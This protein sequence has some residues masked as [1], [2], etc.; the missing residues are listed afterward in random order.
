MLYTQPAVHT[1]R[2]QLTNTFN[3]PLLTLTLALSQPLTL[4]IGPFPAPFGRPC[5]YIQIQELVA[6]RGCIDTFILILAIFLQKS[7]C[8]K[9]FVSIIT[10]P[11]QNGYNVCSYI[12]LHFISFNF[13]FTN[14]K[15]GNG[16]HASCRA[17]PPPRYHLPWV[18]TNHAPA[19]PASF[20]TTHVTHRH[21]GRTGLNI[22]HAPAVKPPKDR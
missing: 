13:L 3:S 16:R 4:T 8:F 12:L 9:N 14:K 10:S 2:W 1:E 18:C 21:T 20:R 17:A 5:V 6:V 11:P 7:L 15:E 22:Q 19:A